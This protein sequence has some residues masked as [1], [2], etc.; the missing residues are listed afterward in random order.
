MNKDTTIAVIM[1]T[2]NGAAYLMEQLDSL[3]IQQNIHV[4]I[5]IRDDG[6]TDNTPAILAMYAE[7]HANIVFVNP[8]NRENL[9]VKNSFLFLL[10]WVLDHHPEINYFAFA[11]Q[12]DVWKKEK[13]SEAL[14]RMNDSTIENG[15]MQMYFSN[16]TIVNKDLQFV[17]EDHLTYFGDYFDLFWHANAY[18]CT[19]VINRPMALLSVKYQ[20]SALF[21][22]DSWIYRLAILCDAQI[23]FDER[24][25]I[26]YRQHE[27]NNCGIDATKMI[28]L[29]DAKRLFSKSQHMVQQKIREIQKWTGDSFSEETKKFVD[30]TLT[31]HHKFSSFCHLAFSKMAIRRGV[32]LYLVFLLKLILHKF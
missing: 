29:K 21:I 6:S 20:P 12:D 25:F 1:S 5:F 3:L 13:L 8:Q 31:Y 27:S 2:Y 11:D 7:R 15:E 30:W 14:A 9:G 26:L 17:K 24:S 28:A 19:M 16:K 4:Q 23:I 10:K 18:G 32:V 22:H